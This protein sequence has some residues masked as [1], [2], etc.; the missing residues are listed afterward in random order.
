MVAFILCRSELQV[1]LKMCVSSGE[2]FSGPSNPHK[3]RVVSLDSL[4]PVGGG[5]ILYIGKKLKRSS[6]MEKNLKFG[7]KCVFR[8]EKSSMGY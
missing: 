1:W 8:P 2:V 5:T 7:R 4:N 3:R 6:C